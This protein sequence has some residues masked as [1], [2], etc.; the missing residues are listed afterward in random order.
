MAIFQG[1]WDKIYK[2]YKNSD[3]LHVLREHNSMDL[4]MEPQIH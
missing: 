2:I 4:S 3:V 1:H